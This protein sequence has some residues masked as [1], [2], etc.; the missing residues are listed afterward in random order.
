MTTKDLKI[1]ADRVADSLNRHQFTKAFLELESRSEVAKSTWQLRE[2]IQQLKKNFS[3]L[4][5]YALDGYDDP[6]REKIADEIV[7]NVSGLSAEI[8]REWESQLNPSIYYSTLRYERTQAQDS[9][10]SLIADL[11]GRFADEILYSAGNKMAEFNKSMADLT[12]RLFNRIWTT[13]P[14]SKDD[15]SAISK[16]MNAES[17]TSDIARLAI[18]A[19]MLGGLMFADDR[20]ITLLLDTYN[21]SSDRGVAIVSLCAAVLLIHRWNDTGLGSDVINRLDVMSDDDSARNDL[22]MIFRQLICTRD[23]ERVN[24][25]LR[26]EIIPKMMNM[27]SDIEAIKHHGLSFD[28]DDGEMNPEWVDLIRKSGI[29]EQIKELN[30]MQMKGADVM[31]GTFGPLKSFPFFNKVANWFRAF[32]DSH[33]DLQQMGNG[34][35]MEIAEIIKITDF[36]CDS[37]KYSAMLYF[38]SM[39]SNAREIMKSMIPSG[40]LADL[41]AEKSSIANGKERLLKDFIQDSYR[42]FNL[43]RRKSDFYNPFARPVNLFSVEAFAPFFSD[44]ESALVFGEFYLSHEY[45]A[46]ALTAFELVP[47]CTRLVSDNI[48]QKIGYCREILGDYAGAIEAYETSEL[49]DGTNRWTLRRLAFVNKKIGEFSKALTY[50]ERLLDANPEDV[51]LNLNVGECLMEI[52]RYKDALNKFF[53]VE[54]INPD[55]EQSMRPIAWCAALSGDSVKAEKYYNKILAGEPTATDFLNAGHWTMSTGQYRNAVAYYNEAVKGY[56]RDGF[57]KFLKA[58]EADSK[59]LKIMKVN[60]MLLDLVADE[61][62]SLQ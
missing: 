50:F 44:D 36:L 2:R 10:S 12:E 21:N 58:L 54:F 4:K 26:D 9:I 18:S 49:I 30:E 11:E 32:D 5:S 43:F 6:E 46:D 19:L 27:R 61:V 55:S 15:V 23:T 57:D 38:G 35:N 48:Q 14:L 60:K 17:F 16:L 29:E 20:R 62:Y 52:G 41:A 25:K 24:R 1:I 7:R 59:Y 51:S 40:D 42:F 28:V 13:H 22:K 3:Y 47:E 56:G 33:P 39:P 37:D 45:Y 34:G 53:K 31:M 8:M